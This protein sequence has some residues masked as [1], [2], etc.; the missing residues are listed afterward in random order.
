MKQFIVIGCGRF[1]SSV[2]KTLYKMGNDVLAIDGHEETVQSI[3]DEVTHAVQADATDEHALRSLGI[4]NFD[5]AVITIGS[6]IQASI[7]ATLIVKELGVKFVVAK[8]QNELHAKV[9][10]KIG[11][12]RVVF[13]ERDMGIR[14]AHNLVSSNILDYIELAPD[15]SI[16]E[17]TA[18]D[19]W[20]D[21]S[22]IEAD[23][24]SKY[25]VNIMAIKHGNEINVSPTALD[26]I[27]RGDVLVVIGHNNDLKK[28]ER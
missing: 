12:D 14:V 13:P 9:L 25:G 24:R 1:G 8:A 28:L 21:K 15:Y 27:H 10:Y 26:V 2:A 4:R 7:M 6:D 16:M 17:I 11:A 18:L 5:V 20:L 23:I 3:S 19:D 22:L